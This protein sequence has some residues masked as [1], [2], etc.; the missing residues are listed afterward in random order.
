MLAGIFHYRQTY[1]PT[2]SNASIDRK[3]PIYHKCLPVRQLREYIF[4]KAEAEIGGNALYI[5]VFSL[6][7]AMQEKSEIFSIRGPSGF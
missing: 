1:P 2:A 7:E 6:L 3:G 5:G 4:C